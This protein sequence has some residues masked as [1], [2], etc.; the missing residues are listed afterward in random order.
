MA[1]SGVLPM[2]GPTDKIKDRPRIHTIHPNIYKLTPIHIGFQTY[3]SALLKDIEVLP[4][5]VPWSLSKCISLILLKRAITAEQTS[6]CFMRPH[7]AD[8]LHVHAVEI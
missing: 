3:C 4:E 6:G 2:A 7:R 5:S 8:F 1:D